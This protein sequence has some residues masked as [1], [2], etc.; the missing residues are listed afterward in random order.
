MDLPTGKTNGADSPHKEITAKPSSI[1]SSDAATLIYLA[2][3]TS[4]AKAGRSSG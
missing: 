1:W 4:S 2:L 3:A